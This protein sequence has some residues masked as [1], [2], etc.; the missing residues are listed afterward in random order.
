LLNAGFCGN[1]DKCAK[2]LVMMGKVV[3]GVANRYN[4]SKFFRQTRI[5]P[6]SLNGSAK[7]RGSY[8]AELME[9]PDDKPGNVKNLLMF[10]NKTPAGCFI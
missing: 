6:L 2:S 10:L 3:T 4:Y 1:G 7:K 8:Y 5:L 9:V